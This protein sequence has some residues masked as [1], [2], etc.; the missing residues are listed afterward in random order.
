MNA[1]VTCYLVFR[2]L[3]QKILF[4]QQRI[5][6]LQFANFCSTTDGDVVLASLDLCLLTVKPVFLTK[7]VK[8]LTS[9]SGN[10]CLIFAP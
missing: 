6:R 9:E 8:S 2:T 1:I 5:L 4:T 7:D 10:P 3:H